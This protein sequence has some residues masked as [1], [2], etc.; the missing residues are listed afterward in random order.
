MVFRGVL[1]GR[2]GP[3]LATIHTSRPR[4]SL[5]SPWMLYLFSV[6]GPLERVDAVPGRFEEPLAGWPES[7]PGIGRA[8]LHLSGLALAA[9]VPRLHPT[10]AYRERPSRGLGDSFRRLRKSGF[11]RIQRVTLE[12][13]EAVPGEPANVLRRGLS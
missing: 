13:P 5:S 7:P 6:A 9:P 8:A 4:R 3:R 1:R 2:P 12:P 10:Y 11:G